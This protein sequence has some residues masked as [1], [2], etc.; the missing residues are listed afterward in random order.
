[1][2]QARRGS[3]ADEL[4][5]QRAA[6]KVSRWVDKATGMHHT[7]LALD[8][9]RDS[10]VFAAAAREL[11]RARQVDGN[12]ET[13]W[14][15]LEVDAWVSCLLG[16]SGSAIPRA[17]PD[18]PPNTSASEGSSRRTPVDRAPQII[19]V[20][21]ARHLRSEAVRTGVCATSDGV[22]LPISTLRRLCCDAEIIPVVMDGPS[23]V[24]DLGRSR[25]TAST[26]QRHALRAMHSSCVFPGC[27]VAFEAC[28]IHHVDWWTRD[29]GRTDLARLVPI[30]EHDHHRI[31]EGGW[32]LTI[33]N[34]RV[35][36]WTRPDGVVH[37]VGRIDDR[38]P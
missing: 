17:R 26:E 14:K 22:D 32:T 38:I 24:L 10:E 16:R 25:R 9:V 12:R 5:A 37:R 4:N 27:D 6:S 7:L 8:P 34:D 23:R 21:D 31:H 18:D 29:V 28:R 11:A 30:C 20:T 3:D 13:P 33:D 35:G 1:M 19:A 36:T 15:Q 2:S